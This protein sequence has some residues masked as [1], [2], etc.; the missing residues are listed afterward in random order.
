[1]VEHRAVAIHAQRQRL[2]VIARCVFDGQVC[3]SQIFRVR[4]RWL[5]IFKRWGFG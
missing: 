2:P 5:I 4:E 1:M 3:A